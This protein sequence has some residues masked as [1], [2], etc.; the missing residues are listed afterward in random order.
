M[1]ECERVGLVLLDHVFGLGS[2]T[3]R[4]RRK[5]VV[6]R[7]GGRYFPAGCW[8]QVLAAGA[9]GTTIHHNFLMD[10]DLTSSPWLLV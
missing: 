1:I 7:D 4:G 3:R 6:E 10:E 9:G 2:P 5:I 8:A